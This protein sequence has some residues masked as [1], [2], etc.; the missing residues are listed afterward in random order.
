M[1]ID[2][3]KQ[4]L[5]LYKLPSGGVKVTLINRILSNSMPE[6]AKILC[7]LK[8]KKDLQ[9]ICSKMELRH[10]GTSH[11]LNNRII[12]NINFDK[13][14]LSDYDFI[15]IN[16]G[17]IAFDYL[18]KPFLLNRYFAKDELKSLC[19]NNDLYISGSKDDLIERL[20]NNNIS[21][22]EILEIISDEGLEEII[23]M[24]N[25]DYD[26]NDDLEQLIIDYL[27]RKN[28]IIKNNYHPNNG[29]EYDIAISFAGEQRS[30]A[31]NIVQEL[32][33]L[34]I[35][36]YYDNDDIINMWGK[37][38]TEHFQSIFRDKSRYCVMLIS[39]E[40]INK[41]WTNHERRSALDRQMRDVAEYILPIK[42][43]DIEIPGLPSSTCYIKYED[44]NEKEIAK[45]IKEKMRS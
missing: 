37:N 15:F 18:D 17:N 30:I 8:S 9:T 34:N 3:L 1:S 42:I 7:T 31:E 6:L 43:D 16:K 23:E 4:I 26:P 40:Y 10:S 19:E 28:A 27:N 35:K 13:R 11:E 22:Q 21:I 33:L 25:L 5:K 36:T 41:S 24:L 29:Y 45:I 14:Y 12:D 39:T 2:E 32:N 44:H 20:I 38:L